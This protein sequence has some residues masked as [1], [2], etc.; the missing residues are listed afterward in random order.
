MKQTVAILTALM[1][2]LVL[3]SGFI[4]MGSM[5]QNDLL[6]QREAQLLARDQELTQKNAQLLQMEA[7]A[8]D[9]LKQQE[10]LI[11]ERDALSQ[12]LSDALLSS[13]ES[14]DAIARQTE[15]AEALLM[16]N[17]R[18]RAQISVLEDEASLTALA[19]E[20]QTK[21]DAQ[22]LQA[23]QKELEEAL[24]PPATSSPLRVERR[25]NP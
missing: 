17:E 16:E 22:K 25:V 13:Q 1:A 15:T 5:Q 9:S 10:Q 23:L 12:Q 4:V 19:W 11:Q 21:E 18:L 8:R 3:I 7:E 6:V 24:M 14:N 2:A 20:Q